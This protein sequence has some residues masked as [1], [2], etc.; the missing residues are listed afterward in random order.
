LKNMV[1]VKSATDALRQLSRG[2]FTQIDEALRQRESI[3]NLATTEA[4]KQHVEAFR[5]YLIE[6]GDVVAKKERMV[7]EVDENIQQAIAQ[8][9][10]LTET[11]NPAAKKF[12][13]IKKKLLISRDELE[14]DI[15]SLKQRAGEALHR[16]Q[17]T[18]EALNRAGIAFVHPVVEQE[19]HSMEVQAKL[20]QY[21]AL[22]V[23]H[24]EGNR[25]MDD[26]TEF[27]YRLD[28]TKREVAAANS[29]VSGTIGRTI[30]LL[31]AAAQ[32]Q[33][34]RLLLQN[35]SNNHNHYY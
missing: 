11:F 31:R 12:G 21:K 16:F 24:T 28:E 20:M 34:Q 4:H 22:A 35:G 8:K 6:L 2:A 23:G 33:Q 10:I 17:R 27:R 13:D 9:E 5:G 7:E 14:Q 19:H 3:L 15:V 18:E 30:P 1:L 25:L 32:Q 29:L 26:I